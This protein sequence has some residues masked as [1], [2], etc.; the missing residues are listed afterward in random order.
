[1]ARFDLAIP[2]VIWNEGGLT[3]DPNDRGGLTNFG[4]SQRS[5][6]NLDIA[7][8][9]QQDAV[10]IYHRDFWKFDGI[11]NQQLADKVFDATVNMGHTAI[12]ILQRL[13]GV[14]DDG[15]YGPAT[16]KAINVMNPGA[17]LG[18][19]RSALV[20]HYEAIV[21]ADPSQVKFLSGWLRRARS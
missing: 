16:E 15:V 2:I 11:M 20:D 1:M 4:I 3:G 5:Y 17:L 8:L 9:T 12:K 19:F 18:Q 6:P 10:N 7:T 14:S 21:A 13:V